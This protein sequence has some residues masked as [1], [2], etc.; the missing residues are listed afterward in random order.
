MHTTQ[1]VVFQ[2]KSPPAR[3]LRWSLPLLAGDTPATPPKG[4]HNIHLTKKKELVQHRGKKR[5]GIL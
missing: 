4:S 2:A 5:M 1:R 3:P